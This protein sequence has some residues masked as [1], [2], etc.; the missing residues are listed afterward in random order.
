[1]DR[2]DE[3][4]RR[5]LLG[6]PY[7]VAF[8]RSYYG[9]RRRRRDLFSWSLYDKECDL[10]GFDAAAY[11][12][13]LGHEPVIMD[14]GCALSYAFGNRFGGR[15]MPVLYVDPLAPFY[16][17]ILRRYRI[18]RPRI[19]YGAVENL[20]ASFAPDSVDLI[21]VRNALDHCAN[22]MQGI[23]QCL[24]CL[25]PGGV[26]YL[27]HFRNEA[28][29]EA[30][31]GFHQFN[32]NEEG[33]RLIL[34][35]KSARIDVT[36]RIAPFADAVTTVSPADGRIICVIRKTAAVPADDVSPLATARATS[37]MLMS[38]ILDFH[39]FGFSARYQLS[40]LIS[41]LGHRTMRLLP[42]NAVARI[43]KI[44]GK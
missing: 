11:V 3:N 14:L 38:A 1:M 24:A 21:H 12:A 30:Y 40:R 10:D 15:P 29:R 2:T 43:K 18:D 7:E 13:S 6:I 16:N 32:L 26:L 37:E 41:A 20:S 34:W 39:S 8:W 33:G 28:C 4:I 22:P 35:N 36:G 27:N 19:T 31:R 44:C 42:I 9:N 17:R 5:W 25:R 23:L